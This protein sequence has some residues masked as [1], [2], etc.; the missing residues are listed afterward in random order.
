[1]QRPGPLR[2]IP[3]DHINFV[4]NVSHPVSFKHKP[5]KRPLSPNAS[6]VCTPAKRQIV[7]TGAAGLSEKSLQALLWSSEDDPSTPVRARVALP[8]ISVTPRK[9]DFGIA[10]SE[11]NSYGSPMKC[12][13]PSPTRP[14]TAFLSP[15]AMDVDDCFTP[16]SSALQLLEPVVFAATDPSSIHYPGFNVHIDGDD[17]SVAML[18]PSLSR[19]PSVGL[20]SAK[21]NKE[22]E[23]DKEN[24]PLRVKSM[25]VGKED[26]LAKVAISASMK[27]VGVENWAPCASEDEVSH[28]PKPRLNPHQLVSRAQAVPWLTPDRALSSNAVKPLSM[29]LMEVGSEGSEWEEDM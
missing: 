25:R 14:T 1:M 23:Q 11:E 12:E 9:L 20:N 24:I 22:K 6:P 10:K 15:D 7:S 2:D 5:N 16:R 28:S 29:R 8:G 21:K 19:K 18:P 17:S 27:A 4:D 13:P 3:L 26:A